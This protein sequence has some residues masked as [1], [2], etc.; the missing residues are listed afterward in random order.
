MPPVRMHESKGNFGNKD[1]GN[2]NRFVNFVYSM[3]TW[4]WFPVCFFLLGGDK[5]A[6]ANTNAISFKHTVNKNQPHQL[7]FA[8]TV[9]L[10]KKQKKQK[11]QK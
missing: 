1:N 7:Q 2:T 10:I 9:V 4:W 8:A 5:R 3:T 11:I 6:F